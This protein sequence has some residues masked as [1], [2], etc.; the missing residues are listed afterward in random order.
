MLGGLKTILSFSLG[1][2]TGTYMA[3]NYH[4]MPKVESP[5]ELFERAKKFI[6]DPQMPEISKAKAKGDGKHKWPSMF[7]VQK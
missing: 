3:Q 4:D 6:Q 2:Y 5:A 1:M 7:L